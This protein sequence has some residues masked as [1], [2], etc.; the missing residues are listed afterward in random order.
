MRR[1]LIYILTSFLCGHLSAQD[2]NPRTVNYQKVDSVI[3]SFTQ[4]KFT[5]PKQLADYIN[6]T[7]KNDHEKLRAIFRWVTNNINYCYNTSSNPEQ[8]FK[9]KKAVCQ[10]Y[11]VLVKHL[12]DLTKLE[13]IVVDGIAKN[14][15]VYLDNPIDTSN[16]AWNVVTLY[17][18]KYLMDATWASGYLNY[19]SKT[20][21][22]EFIN[23]Y[24]L[25]IPETFIL[26]H[27]PTNPD[28]QFLTNKVSIKDFCKGPS[29][30]EG[31]VKCELVSFNPVLA[32]INTVKM[33]QTNFSFEIKKQIK[34]VDIKIIDSPK[35]DYEEKNSVDFEQT[36][37]KVTFYWEFEKTGL[38]YLIIY[39]DNDQAV[40]YK[41]D[42][43]E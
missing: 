23:D 3:L 24:Y 11:S 15:I 22:K 18:K 34:D 2:I 28:Y 12:C 16:H 1:L 42:I 43:N 27:L 8:V 10:G 6:S 17:E 5:S 4:D 36:G 20:F 26:Q 9:T 31:A 29:F 7:F 33:A 35:Q 13:C 30:H 40:F 39:I 25:T 32:K 21:T 41:V 14:D 37:D 38:F 19:E